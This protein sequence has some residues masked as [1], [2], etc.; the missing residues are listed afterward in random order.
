MVSA[1]AVLFLLIW[2]LGLFVSPFFL[3]LLGLPI[4]IGGIWLGD[5]TSKHLANID[6]YVTRDHPL[7]SEGE[8]PWVI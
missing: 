7:D 6:E 4:V 1:C 8:P 2:I 5:L 3:L